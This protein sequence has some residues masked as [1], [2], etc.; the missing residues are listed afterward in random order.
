MLKLLYS[1]D[2]LRVKRLFFVLD[3]LLCFIYIKATV[4]SRDCLPASWQ[5]RSAASVHQHL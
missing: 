3:I 2:C 4:Q 5:C 1:Q